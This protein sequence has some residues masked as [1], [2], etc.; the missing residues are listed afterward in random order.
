MYSILIKQKTKRTLCF[1]C[2]MMIWSFIFLVSLYSSAVFDKNKTEHT[3]YGQ[4]LW[5]T[6]SLVVF[7]V[8]YVIFAMNK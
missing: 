3:N 5:L 4:F 7:N 1:T 8:V 2:T 6:D